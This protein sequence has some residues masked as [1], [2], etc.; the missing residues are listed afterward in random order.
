[1][2]GCC[3]PLVVQQAQSPAHF[4]NKSDLILAVGSSL[5]PRRFS[6]AF[7]VG[8]KRPSPTATLTKPCFDSEVTAIPAGC[9]ARGS[10]APMRP[11]CASTGAPIGTGAFH[12]DQVVIHVV[13]QQPRRQRGHRDDG[14]PSTDDL[15]LRPLWRTA[16]ACRSV[17]GLPGC[18]RNS[19]SPSDT[20]RISDHPSVTTPPWKPLK[21]G[22]LEEPSRLA[23]IVQTQDDLVIGELDAVAL[24]IPWYV[25]IN[26]RQDV[27]RFF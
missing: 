8:Q 23:F 5:S 6:H 18:A 27:L 24:L 4:L 10:L 13:A 19:G 20:S 14:R 26:Q 7:L 9:A 15:G 1:M 22:H 12:N 21:L 17:A 11:P 25:R 2:I 3:E 16:G